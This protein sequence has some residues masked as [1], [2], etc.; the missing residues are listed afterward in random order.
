VFVNWVKL[1]H[2]KAIVNIKENIEAIGPRKKT[3]KQNVPFGK[4]SVAFSKLEQ[5]E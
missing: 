1:L 4:P 3:K 5:T 2:P